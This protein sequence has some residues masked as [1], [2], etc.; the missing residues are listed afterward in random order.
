VGE[1]A[2]PGGAA[3]LPWLSE[4][5]DCARGPV[6]VFPTAC[7]RRYRAYMPVASVTTASPV[8][9]VNADLAA[10]AWLD[11][12]PSSGPPV[13]AYEVHRCCGGGKVCTVRVRST[14][15]SDDGDAYVK[16]RLDDG[17]E[18]LIDRRA[19]ARLPSRFGLTVNGVG[20]FRR[21]DLELD[22]YDW[23]TLLY[24]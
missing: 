4:R 18:V 16:A 7:V 5:R 12:H 14:C 19:A 6:L 2:N 1:L 15:R 8:I 10:R 20:P 9:Q 17:A 11:S 3:L 24:S 23:G 22:P 21:L 13:I